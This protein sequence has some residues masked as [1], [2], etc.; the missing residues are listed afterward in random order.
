MKNKPKK[1]EKLKSTTEVVLRKMDPISDV[2]AAV[3]AEFG[4]GSLRRV[5]DKSLTIPVTGVYSTG[6][7]SVDAAWGR[8]GIPWGR[9][10]IFHGKEGCG[11]TTLALTTAAEA[12]RAGALVVYIDAEFKLD[13]TWAQKC[14]LDLS[15]VLL[16]QPEYLERAISLVD[17]VVRK[18]ADAKL[19]SFI[20]L[21]SIN[22]CDTKAEFE[23]NYEEEEHYGPKARVYSRALPKIARLVK[24]AD[25]ALLLVSQVRGGPNGNHIAC[26]N[27]PRF[28][29][30]CIA[31]FDKPFKGHRITSGDRVV[32]VEFEVE[33]VKNQVAAPYQK[34]RF[35]I[36]PDGPDTD[37]SLMDAAVSL[38]LVS[39]GAAGWYEWA[40]LD[41]DTVKF[42]GVL[43]WKKIVEKDPTAPEELRGAVRKKYGD[44]R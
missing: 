29:S 25:A 28:Y 27:A 34:A 44:A 12:Q 11:K 8:G 39:K 31:T 5:S 35:R 37:Q 33:F 13:L 41:G 10:A 9:I 36:S 20:V 26:G 3:D 19:K 7:E 22:A 30:S 18:A 6:F 43:G 32:A 4:K 42:Q 17:S 40:R 1:N 24:Q 38:G 23:C 16:S 21:D 2:V 15:D 14:G